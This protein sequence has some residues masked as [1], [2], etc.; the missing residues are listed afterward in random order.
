MVI[1]KFTVIGKVTAESPLNSPL[2]YSL[3][4]DDNSENFVMN[5]KT[6]VFFYETYK[7]NKT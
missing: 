2:N 5:T 6:G 1:Q 4:S 3:I 7:I